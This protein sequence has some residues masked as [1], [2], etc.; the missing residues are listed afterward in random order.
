MTDYKKDTYAWSKEQCEHLRLGRFDQLDIENLIDEINSVGQ[1]ERRAF[2][3]E[4]ATCIGFMLCHMPNAGMWKGSIEY[5]RRHAAR[6]LRDNPSLADEEAEIMG[7]VYPCA[8]AFAV[9]ESG[10]EENSFPTTCPW[11]LAEILKD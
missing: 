8:V 10:K 2:K 7:Q 9:G 6:T 4:L 1:Q 11:T 5:Y 3:D